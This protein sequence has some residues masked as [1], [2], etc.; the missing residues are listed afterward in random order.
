[1]G[2]RPARRPEKFDQDLRK[3]GIKLLYYGLTS[4]TPD[5]NPTY[6]LYKKLWDSSFSASFGPCVLA[7]HAAASSTLGPQRRR[8]GRGGSGR[9]RPASGEAPVSVGCGGTAQRA[10][11][12]CAQ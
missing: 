3:Q 8:R 11:G 9:S 2:S 12:A 10:R 7:P 4:C 1:M 6:D 5:R